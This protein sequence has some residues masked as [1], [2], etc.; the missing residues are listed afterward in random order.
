MLFIL[1]VVVVV[2]V[3]AVV[4]VAV[5]LVVVVVVLRKILAFSSSSSCS[6]SCCCCV[7]S[8]F[9]RG[10]TTTTLCLLTAF[11]YRYICTVVHSLLL[12]ECRSKFWEA[13]SVSHV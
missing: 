7:L 6:C 10:Q 2:V 3:A 8:D 12:H 4:V 1:V 5:V 13:S 11:L 9:C